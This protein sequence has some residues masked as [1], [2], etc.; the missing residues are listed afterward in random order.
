MGSRENRVE[1]SISGCGVAAGFLSTA[2]LSCSHKYRWP[3]AKEYPSG[4]QPLTLMRKLIMSGTF[5]GGTED[6]PTM[7]RTDAGE[8][9][10]A[11]VKQNKKASYNELKGQIKM[12]EP[13]KT[14][15]LFRTTAKLEPCQ[16][17]L[18]VE[19]GLVPGVRGESSASKLMLNSF[20]RTIMESAA[21]HLG[22]A[23]ALLVR[24]KISRTY[25]PL[26]NESMSKTKAV[27]S[28]HSERNVAR[29]PPP[30]R[31]FADISAFQTKVQVRNANSTAF[32]KGLP[33]TFPNT[34]TTDV[35][36]A[37]DVA[38]LLI[39]GKVRSVSQCV[40]KSKFKTRSR[41]PVIRL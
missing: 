30:K 24:H 28:S 36:P 14:N 19:I 18:R 16:Q 5:P 13:P 27:E 38:H 39:D 2:Q 9:L 40:A 21:Q 41:S 34:I 37:A 7:F 25:K 26:S 35:K 31:V 29:S 12:E 15:V 6:K 23:K 4:L 3:Q 8:V 33:I 20:S 1:V 32:T 11:A 22:E 10:Q 17:K